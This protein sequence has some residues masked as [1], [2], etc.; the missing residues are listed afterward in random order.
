MKRKR[1]HQLLF[2][3]TDTEL[4]LFNSKQS[5]SGLNKTEFLLS[6]LKSATLKVYAFEDSARQLGYELRKM[7]V[8]L[9]QVAHLVNSGYFNLA[10]ESY[11]KMQGA[12][13]EVFERLK[14]FLEKPLLNARIMEKPPDKDGE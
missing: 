5:A 9:N 6:L 1:N 8:N 3:L 2:R 13:F 10:Q 7:G 4:A 14:T 12:Y 11:S